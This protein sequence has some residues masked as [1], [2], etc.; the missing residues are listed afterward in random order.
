MPPEGVH[1][2]QLLLPSVFL[3]ELLYRRY[4]V[5]RMQKELARATFSDIPVF[6]AAQ[7]TKG[8]CH[9][10]APGPGW[11][12]GRGLRRANFGA[13]SLAA[14]IILEAQR[15]GEPAAWVAAADSVFFPP[16]LSRRGVDLSALAVIRAGGQTESLTA[17]EWLAG[18]G[19]V[20][21]VVVDCDGQWNVSDA[22]L[23]RIQ[24]L[25]ERSKCAVVFLTRKRC[26]D[27][28]LGSRISL[29]GCVSRSDAGPF[30][31]D[32]HAAKDKR[33]HPGSRQRRHYH[34]PPGMH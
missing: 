34:G 13:L 11:N 17:A 20:G 1:R 2:G 26:S 15:H 29:R 8:L 24:K 27:P 25:A 6:R 16:D 28:S 33:S 7:L 23:G 3:D 10:G 4:P 22:S 19:A 32:L 12:P 5:L 21:L 14:E 30:Q 9:L 31:V 18:S